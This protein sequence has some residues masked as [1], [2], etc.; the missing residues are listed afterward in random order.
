LIS[1]FSVGPSN[2]L[3]ARNTVL[4]VTIAR[5]FRSEIIIAKRGKASNGKKVMKVMDLA[6]TDGDKVT[7]FVNG[8]D[9]QAAICKLKKPVRQGIKINSY[10]SR[11]K[12]IS[13][14]PQI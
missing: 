6:V 4:F 7:L 9:E 2:G 13:L 3:Q 5:T 10:S 1:R 11:M 14:S 12:K 8:E